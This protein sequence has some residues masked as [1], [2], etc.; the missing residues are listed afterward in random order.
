VALR[1]NI[2]FRPADLVFLVK[3]VDQTAHLN[4]PILE[5]GCFAGA[6]AISLNKYLVASGIVERFQECHMD[7]GPI[8]PSTTLP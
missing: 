3:C 8:A 2:C 4:G 6:T 1:Y 5:I 7:Q